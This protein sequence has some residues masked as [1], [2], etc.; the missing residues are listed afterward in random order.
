MTMIEDLL[1]SAGAQFPLAR[2]ETAHP[3]WDEPSPVG[4]RP[5]GLRRMCPVLA[6]SG[7]WL[8]WGYDHNRQLA[9]DRDGY[10]LTGGQTTTTL[11]DRD[12]VN[13][14]CIKLAGAGFHGGGVPV[15]SVRVLGWTWW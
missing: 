3:S 1:A 15:V 9:T 14:V 5:W 4:V 10:T 12:D 6:P 8:G 7:R 13:R 11:R 2:P